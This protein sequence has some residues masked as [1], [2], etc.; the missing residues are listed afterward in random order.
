MEYRPLININDTG[1]SSKKLSFEEQQQHVQVFFK[2]K[3]E[4]LMSV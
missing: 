2:N 4:S 1:K 3:M